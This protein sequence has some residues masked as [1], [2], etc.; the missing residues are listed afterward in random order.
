MPKLD[1]EPV[2]RIH[3]QLYASDVQ[4]LRVRYADTIGIGPAVRNIVRIFLKRL[5]DHVPQATARVE[6]EE[7]E[8]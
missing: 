8:L 7:M 4:T 6:L 2:E 3:I 1:G 5:E